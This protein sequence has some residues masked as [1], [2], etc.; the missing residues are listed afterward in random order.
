M[1]SEVVD[2]HLQLCDDLLVLLK[3]ENRLLRGDPSGMT[4]EF[5]QQKRDLLPRL[6][7]S[8]AALK[9]I[10]EESPEMLPALREKLDSAQKKIMRI[11]L[12]DKENEQLLLKSMIPVKQKTSAPAGSMQS[13]KSIYDKHRIMPAG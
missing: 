1:G 12:L 5:L 13:L 4:E 3:E 6:D 8:L 2:R 11:L 7:E 10:Q 9:T